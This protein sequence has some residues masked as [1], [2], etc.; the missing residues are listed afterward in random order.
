MLRF[1]LPSAATD[2]D[3]DR[4]KCFPGD[5]LLGRLDTESREPNRL[6]SAASPGERAGIDE[7]LRVVCILLKSGKH[8]RGILKVNKL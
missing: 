2:T 3:T 4:E 1:V 5:A 7:G 8:W 6:R